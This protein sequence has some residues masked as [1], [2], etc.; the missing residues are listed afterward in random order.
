MLVLSGPTISIY[1]NGATTDVTAY[2]SPVL[3]LDIWYQ[4]TIASISN[5]IS[6]YVNGVLQNTPTSMSISNDEMNF[7]TIGCLTWEFIPDFPF[8]GKIA[9]V[10]YYNVG[11][12]D[13]ETATYFNNTK[14]RY[15]Y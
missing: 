14:A 15:G 10:E 8:N 11:L 7:I 12:T 2:P 4:L 6:I 1:S 13:A 3:S 5:V 9:V